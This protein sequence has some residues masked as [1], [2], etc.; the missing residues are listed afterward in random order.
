MERLV[1]DPDW[2]NISKASKGDEDAF[3]ILVKKYEAPVSSLIY[4]YTGGANADDLVQEVFI[5]VWQ[6]ASSFKGRSKFS[7][8]LYRVA[9]NHCL[10]YRSKQKSGLTSE[11]DESVPDNSPDAQAVYEVKE[12]ADLVR[13]AIAGLSSKQRMA[14][15]LFKFEG[16]SVA[17]VADIMELSFSATQSLI[18]RAIDNLRKRLV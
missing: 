7:T 8:W 2:E 3:G 15:L 17:E 1:C 13:K 4:R 18:F 11:L 9:V 5:K 16:Y 10:N 14:I 6:K 12:R